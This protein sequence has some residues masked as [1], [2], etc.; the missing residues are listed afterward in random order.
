MCP[1]LI[2]VSIQ[3][4]SNEVISNLD[5]NLGHIVAGQ[6]VDSLSKNENFL[7]YEARVLRT[8][9]TR[10]LNIYQ[11]ECALQRLV[12]YLFEYLQTIPIPT[13]APGSGRSSATGGTSDVGSTSDVGGTGAA[14]G[15]GYSGAS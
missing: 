12:N 5:E 9:P 4:Y 10:R 11:N 3:E 6:S 1:F 13:D 15:D 8:A 2:V 14:V 7:Q